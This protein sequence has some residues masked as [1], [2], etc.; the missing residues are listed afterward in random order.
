MTTAPTPDTYFPKGPL[1]WWPRAFQA[2]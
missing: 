2:R 1:V